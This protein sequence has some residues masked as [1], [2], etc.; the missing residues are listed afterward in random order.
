MIKDFYVHLVKAGPKRA[1]IG[2]QIEFRSSNKSPNEWST[3]CQKIL[4]A[5][6]EPSVHCAGI[7]LIIKGCSMVKQM[8][9]PSNHTSHPS[10]RD[11]VLRSGMLLYLHLK[12]I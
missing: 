9:W 3:S 8:I 7:L 6:Q 2:S 1:P 10:I 12:R 4:S 11:G 5:A